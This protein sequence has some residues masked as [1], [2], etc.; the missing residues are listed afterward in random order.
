MTIGLLSLAT[1]GCTR[2]IALAPESNSRLKPAAQSIPAEERVPLVIDHLHLTRNGA[3]GPFPTDLERQVAGAVQNTHLFSALMAFGDA[4]PARSEKTVLAR[5][6]LDETID[7][8]S[9]TAAWKSFL[10]G[11][12]MFLLSPIME[13]EYDYA[14]QA[15][16]E[17][18]RWDGHVTRYEAQASGTAHYNVFGAT[19]LM[20]EELKGRVLDACLVE[21]IDRM[22]QDTPAYLASSAPH[23]DPAIR[24]ISVTSRKPS[25]SSSARPV[26]SSRP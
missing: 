17:L 19:P 22:I 11:A 15:T 4:A 20:I 16:L 18:E 25:P 5:L 13:L 23:P 7:P 9:G 24:S 10:I 3:P 2:W 1:V 14:A 6:T 8:H 21:L 26:S 12:S